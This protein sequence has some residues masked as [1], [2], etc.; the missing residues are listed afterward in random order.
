MAPGSGPCRYRASIRS[1]KYLHSMSLWRVSFSCSSESPTRHCSA[2]AFLSLTRVAMSG[3]VQRLAG[4][5]EEGLADALG[6]RRV[7]MDQRGHFGGKR[8]PLY[9]QHPPGG[10]V[11]EVR[12]PPVK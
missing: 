9:E 6:Q 8:F 1:S 7:R 3:P 11:R 12:P 2:A 5:C 10:V 4:E